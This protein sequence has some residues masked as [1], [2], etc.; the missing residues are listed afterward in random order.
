MT[1]YLTLPK[2]G[3]TDEQVKA[4]L[5]RLSQMEHVRW[6]DGFVSGTVYHGGK[7]LLDI[8]MEAIRKFAASNPIHPDCFPS[9]RKMEAEIVA[10]VRS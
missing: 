10:M 7:E 9:V 1:R 6:E 5:D 2:E 4:E 8:Q 3:W